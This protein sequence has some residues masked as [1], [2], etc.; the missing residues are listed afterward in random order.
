LS[1]LVFPGVGHFSLKK[2]VQGLLLSIVSI[3]CLYFLLTITVELVQ[4]LSVKIQSGE[5]PMD[6]AKISDIVLQQI[7][8]RDDQR[9]NMPSLVLLICWVLGV[10]DSF[11]IEWLRGHTDD[12]SNKKT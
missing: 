2:P 11:R 8:D 12:L 5:I 4:Q 9:I 1:V 3:V 6:V 7:V 10:V